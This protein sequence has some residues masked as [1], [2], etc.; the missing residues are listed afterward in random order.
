MC[1]SGVGAGSGLCGALQVPFSQENNYTVTSLNLSDNDITFEGIQSLC[2]MLYQNYYTLTHLNLSRCRDLGPDT[3]EALTE[4]LGVHK[5]LTSLDISYNNLGDEGCR[6]LM[7]RVQQS[8]HLVHL[9]IEGCRCSRTTFKRTSVLTMA[10]RYAPDLK[11]RF[12]NIMDGKEAP[13][14]YP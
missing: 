10:N 11:S 12:I 13:Q 9:D 14:V 4:V 5:N 1:A 8:S 7:N 2:K 3:C 6:F